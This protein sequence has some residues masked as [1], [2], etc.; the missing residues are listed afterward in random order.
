MKFM[1]AC[2]TIKSVVKL[3]KIPFPSGKYWIGDPRHIF[4]EEEQGELF[5][6]LSPHRLLEEWSKYDMSYEDFRFACHCKGLV[7]SFRIGTYI[8]YYTNA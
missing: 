2:I 6:E 3:N 5:P 1:K 4:D 8:Q 7:E